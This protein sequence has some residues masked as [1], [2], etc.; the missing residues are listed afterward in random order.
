MTTISEKTVMVLLAGFAILCF[1]SQDAFAATIFFDDFKDVSYNGLTTSGTGATPTH[2]LTPTPRS[3][4]TSTLTPT[5]HPYPTPSSGIYDPHSGDGNVTRTLLTYQVM[6]A[7]NDGLKSF[8]DNSAFAVPANAANP[9]HTFEGTLDL[10][11]QNRTLGN[12]KKRYDPYDYDYLQ[13]MTRLPDITVDLV[14][15]G[16]WLLPK[17]RGMQEGIWMETGS[18]QPWGFDFMIHPGRVWKENSDNGLTR[19]ALPFSLV[20]TNENCTHNGLMTFLFDDSGII[21]HVRYQVPNETCYYYIIDMYGHIDAIYSPHAVSGASTVKTA[22]VNERLDMIPT[23][24]YTDL[25]KEFGVDLNKFAASAQRSGD[26]TSKAV[27]YNGYNYVWPC[28]TRAGHHP[29]CE[30]VMFPAYSTAKIWLAAT[31]MML[32]GKNDPAVYSA[33][34]TDWVPEAPS[35][36]SNVTIENAIDMATGF[37]DNH[38]FIEDENTNGGSFAVARSKGEKTTIAFD[39]YPTQKA[40]PGA[41]FVYHTS[42]TFIAT[43][44]LEAYHGSDIWDYLWNSIYGPLDIG[45]DSRVVLRTWD[46]GGWNNG[47]AIGG[48]G[49][50]YNHDTIAKITRFMNQDIG[51][52]NGAQMLDRN[53]VMAAFQRDPSDIGPDTTYDNSMYILRKKIWKRYNN[54]YWS[55]RYLAG[56]TYENITYSCTWFSARGQGLGGIQLKMMPNGVNFS[57]IS[58]SLVYDSQDAVAQIN[59]ISPHCP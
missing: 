38:D 37:Y 7:S 6:M 3:P 11:P 28:Y 18:S 27:Y 4:P 54:A 43:R 19:A 23:R 10:T 52:V 33:K 1:A 49:L 56:E 36:W 5:L 41:T 32:I 15:H 34:I 59:N 29:Y 35:R 25:A 12:Y 44:A 39:L 26:I 53:Q 40:S 57:Y 24:P 58:D 31:A 2:A 9:D 22:F 51:K 21:S 8:V 46:N 47:I 30:Y 16:T 13:S 42:D 20:I 55:Y 48:Y 14:Q 45:P 50:F 17:D